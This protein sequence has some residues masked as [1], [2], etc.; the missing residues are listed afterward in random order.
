MKKYGKKVLLGAA[1][2]VMGVSAIIAGTHSKYFNKVTGNGEIE[3][4][5]WH[6]DVND[7]TETMANINLAETYNKDTLVNEKIAPRYKRKF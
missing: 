7:A 4:A 6:F 3:I 1:I 2:A 5:K